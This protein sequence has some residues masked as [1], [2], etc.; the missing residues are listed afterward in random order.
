MAAALD[1]GAV[2]PAVP[3]AALQ[4]RWRGLVLV[5]VGACVV[6]LA[7]LLVQA[8]QLQ[9]LNAI[10]HTGS[11]LRVVESQRQ[12][13]EYLQLREQW[14]RA[15]DPTLP[16]DLRALSL[17]YEIWV[18]RVAMLRDNT[19]VRR[20]A[21]DA[22]TNLD[23]TLDRIDRF[24]HDADA[25][26]AG[27]ASPEA[28]RSALR[29]LQPRLVA[30]GEP[31]H[32]LALSAG[33]RANQ[34][35]TER[36][37]LISQHTRVTLA[38]TAVL[39]LLVLTFVGL[40]LRQMR[41]LSRR[42]QAL[43]KLTEDLH[44]ARQVALAAS[45]AKSHFLANMSHEIRTPF[46]GLVGM[47]SML[48]DTPLDAHQVDCL[49]TA[50]E[51]ADHLLAVVNDILDLSQ[52]EAGRLQIQPIGVELCSL[53]QEV[54][55][56]MQ[57]QAQARQLALRVHADPAVPARARLDPTRVRQ[58]LFN[59]LSNAIKFSERGVVELELR[60]LSGEGGAQRLAFKVTD[61][62]VGMDGA[63]LS[64]LFGR[65]ERGDALR[66]DAPGGTG[67]GLEISRNLAR[68]MGGDLEASSQLGQGSCFTLTL[69]MEPASEVL[70]LPVPDTPSP[71]PPSGLQLLVAEDHPVNRQV[72]AALLD[73]MGH[74][75]LFVAGG[76]E[77]VQ[78]VQR[79][80]FDL[81]LMDLHMP[82]VDGIE[83]TRR[84]R[85][86]DDRSA[87][88]VPIVALTADAFTDTRDRCLVAGM[89]DFLGKPVGRDK[90]AA[91]LRQLFGSAAGVER[92]GPGEQPLPERAE[93][94]DAAALPLI[95]A[96]T[97]ARARQLL[98]S[99]RHAEVLATYLDQSARTVARLRLA[100][101]E[102]QTQELQELAHASRGAALALGLSALAGT[103]EALQKGAAH[104]PAHEIARLV[105]CF[106]EQLARTRS[107]AERAGLLPGTIAAG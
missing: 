22:L 9:R 106:D 29:E 20:T 43:Q 8:R 79:Q 41:Q 3:Q 16:L 17:R 39:A 70:P 44:A 105:Q 81:V 47:L 98:S 48:R 40:S 1:R 34:D 45:Q 61:T 4:P 73:S 10:I 99:Q 88:T 87:A 12:E 86:L 52:L 71:L 59:L 13:T 68:L 56:L 57:P 27:E 46:Q 23:S 102:A 77:A 100:V 55:A 84:I 25:A 32:E 58:V 85:A 18:G 26:L 75:S 94:A 30:L 104:L 92:D 19:A 60:L 103:A 80:R 91:L 95:D 14:Q 82:G 42:Q 11:D 2:T 15:L 107:A 67:L 36:H 74:R 54:E 31:I 51:S 62:G 65:F 37:L 97:V 7:V 21:I 89:N 35:Q 6:I 24:V 83:A 53:L 72:L 5:A 64:R 50:T 28:R 90:L 69:P 93:L 49:R 96:L 38:L 33:H 101:R 66:P 76:D 78:A 63:T